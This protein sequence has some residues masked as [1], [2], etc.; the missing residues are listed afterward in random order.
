MAYHQLD[1]KSLSHALESLS[2]L[3]GF[4]YS[5]YDDQLHRIISPAK[6]DALLS[7]VKSTEKG[8]ALYRSFI[9]EQVRGALAGKNPFMKQSFTLQYHIIIPVHYKELRLVAI[10]EA[11]YASPSDFERFHEEDALKSVFSGRPKES[12]RKEI[13]VIPAAQVAGRL[14]RIRSLVEII[15]ASECE[16]GWLNKR[17]RSSKTIVSLMANMNSDAPIK[18][19]YRN[20]IDAVLFLFDV[21]TAAVFSRE[22]EKDVFSPE[23]SA[24]RLRD[25]IRGIRISGHNSFFSQAS[26]TGKPVAVRDG[27]ELRQTGFPG[28]IVSMYLFPVTSSFGSF[29]FLAVFNS[30][31]DSESVDAVLELC[32]LSSSLCGIRQQKEEYE[33]ETLSW[34]QV[35]ERIFNLYTLFRE[36]D[37]LYEGIVND[38]SSLVGAEKCSLMMP[39][40]G[41][42][43]LRVFAAKGADRWL[44]GNIKVRPGE[45]IA[46]RVFERGEPIL[47]DREEAIRQYT[48]TVKPRYRTPSSISMPLK[49]ADETIG[50]LT[51]S[52]KYSGEP[53]SQND[54]SAV[55]HFAFQASILLRLSDYYE[56][57]EQMRE[58]SITDPLTGL[59]NR[60]YFDI[61]LDEESQRAKRYGLP[62]SLV[63]LDIDN[64]KLFND[65]EGHLAGDFI[66]KEI[67]AVMSA[68]VRAHD[69]LVRFGGEEFVILMPQTAKEDALRVSERIRKN[70]REQ[71]PL[72]WSKFP[73]R[74]ITISAGVSM[75]PECGGLKDHLIRCADKV[76][77]KA[78]IQGKDR[79]CVWEGTGYPKTQEG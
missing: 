38:A 56:Q 27:R 79:I 70:V 61:R 75:Y 58:L 54:L 51:L 6:E 45:G 12:W 11:F 60:R 74:H 14:R 10:A 59:F 67:A 3:T 16:K 46:G 57:S 5:L 9:E 34:G 1:L 28:E 63:L 21:D 41:E 17:W 53:F 62:L 49:V 44:M 48:T 29:G 42:K 26:V 4:H 30:V 72:T 8:R 47:T 37:R 20:I 36:P 25:A 73:A 68:A 22:R 40:F 23:I 50:V 52:D 43:M 64:F 39:D 32:M 76:L 15:V 2:A 55:T 77:Y 31:L 19:I 24:G 71:I 65:S 69:I 35:S 18:E 78:K 7:A 33:K 66:L 13:S